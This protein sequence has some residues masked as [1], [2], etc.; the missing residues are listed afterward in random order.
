MYFDSSNITKIINNC[1][2]QIIEDELKKLVSFSNNNHNSEIWF[3][4]A[5]HGIT[6]YNS[7]ENDKQSELLVPEDYRISGFISDCWIFSEF[8]SKLHSSSKVFLLID[9][10]HSGTIC[11]LPYSKINRNSCMEWVDNFNSDL[12]KQINLAN[13]IKI[14]GCKDNQT[15]AD[16]Y[17]N[18]KFQGA[19]SSTFKN[20]ISKVL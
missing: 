15:S 12:A 18:Q 11:N 3:S 13:I 1:N 4:F 17:I 7:N 19:M 8:I 9:C 5:G 20:C 14:S 2:K 10:C 16:A 6:Q